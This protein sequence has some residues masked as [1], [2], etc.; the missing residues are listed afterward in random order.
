MTNIM[1]SLWLTLLIAC[2]L[3]PTT[4]Y[5]FG[6]QS[7][8]SKHHHHQYQPQQQ[9]PHQSSL[10]NDTPSTEHQKSSPMY[11]T[12]LLQDELRLQEE[13]KKNRTLPA[14]PQRSFF[15]MYPKSLL[16]NRD[17]LKEFANLDPDSLR[18]SS[19][20]SEPSGDDEDDSGID[21]AWLL[22]VWQ[23]MK[24]FYLPSAKY[25]DN[26]DCEKDTS[27]INIILHYK[28]L[29]RPI[30]KR[31]AL[32]DLA[33]PLPFSYGT[34]MPSTCTSD[35][36]L[37]RPL[38]STCTSDNLLVNPGGIFG[39]LIV[40]L[41]SCDV[42][43]LQLQQSPREV[44]LGFSLYT[45]LRKVFTYDN[46]SGADLITCLPALRVLTMCWIIICHQYEANFDFLA[47]TFDSLR[48]IPGPSHKPGGDQWVAVSGPFLF[49][50][51]LVLTYR[52]LP[53]I[54]SHRPATQLLLFCTAFLRRFFRL[55]P[56]IF[57]V[58]LFCASLLRF[59]AYG[60]R[61]QVLRSFSQDQCADHW[62]KDPLF[63][64]N[65]ILGENKGFNV[66]DVSGE[67][68]VGELELGDAAGYPGAP[69]YHHRLQPPSFTTPLHTVIVVLG[70]V[71]AV[72]L[73]LILV[74]GLYPYN[75]VF[76]DEKYINY[77]TMSAVYGAL[78]RPVWGLCVAWV[79][80]TCHTGNADMVDRILSYP[81][82]RPLA[83]L[84]FCMYLVAPVVQLWWSSV[85]YVPNYYNYLNKLF[86]SAGVMFIAGV[87]SILLTCIIELPVNF[88]FDLFI[89]SSAKKQER[90]VKMVTPSKVSHDI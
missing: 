68:R 42:I 15:P 56:T 60:P 78:A 41:T 19:S 28:K 11:Q 89:P 51:G 22:K 14:T 87:V 50:T 59:L 4:V 63:V 39:V 16:E 40:M 34:C 46:Q 10:P 38:P 24:S 84:T 69:D 62:W 76:P 71:A 26:Q 79:V 48:V 13:R 36:L 81:G 20:P 32:V 47:N 35:N 64:N 80:F 44:L 52:L 25:I 82:W 57:C 77:P 27:D 37:V 45:N 55:A 5:C 6:P 1:L 86:E 49:M 75:H 7:L 12:S 58:S 88:V 9:I 83:R 73:G 43:L 65:F 74:L 17:L 67:G 53:T 30:L 72:S 61:A 90:M 29:L 70:Y 23:D 66:N 8:V 33:S 31:A 54:T 3:Q 85:Q 2:L 18:L 21:P